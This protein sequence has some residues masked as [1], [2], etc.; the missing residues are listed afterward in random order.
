MNEDDTHITLY[1]LRDDPDDEDNCKTKEGMEDNFW[2]FLFKSGL[3]K[4]T[5]RCA[6]V[7]TQI[8]EGCIVARVRMLLVGYKKI[9]SV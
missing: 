2:N 6:I 8:T 3:D 9:P 1:Y 5:G 4:R 7:G